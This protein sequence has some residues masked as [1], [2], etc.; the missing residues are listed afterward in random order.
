LFV[1]NAAGNAVLE[2]RNLS[3]TLSAGLLKVDKFVMTNSCASFIHSGGA[4]VYG[5][6]VLDPARDDDGDG[7][8][9]GYEQS[10]G[11]DP[12]NPADASI[13]SDGD[14]LSNLQEFLAGTDA[15]NSAS[16]FGITAVVK[17]NIDVGITWMTGLGKTN[18]LERTAGTANG[19]YSNNFAA[20]FTVTN[21]VGNS[22]NYLDV[23]AATN[24]PA[25]Y[26]R[27]RLV[28]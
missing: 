28:P 6:A 18:A 25:Q 20:I 27:V 7:I 12:L 14:G 23:S 1:T 15:T 19:S 3:V 10:H 5:Q 16:F 21:T 9:N 26:Y 11:L 17:T 13:D 22:T 4:L 2:I 24:T 8:P